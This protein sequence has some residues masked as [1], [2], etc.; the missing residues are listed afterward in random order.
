MRRPSWNKSQVIQQVISL[1][2]LLETTSDSNSDGAPMRLYIPY[3][4]NHSPGHSDSDPPDS[5]VLVMAEESVTN[6]P[7]DS[8]KL[9]APSDISGQIAPAGNNSVS[10]RTVEVTNEPVGQMTIFYRGKV[11]VFDDVPGDKARILMEL[12]ASPL[13][14]PRAT[15][16]EVITTLWPFQCHLQAAEIKLDPTS[17]PVIFP[18]LQTGTSA[19][20]YQKDKIRFFLFIYMIIQRIIE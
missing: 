9:D 7:C 12:A 10:I 14:L 15:P 4:G 17:P 18:R 2:A 16:S 8:P 3:P 1:K 13:L 11:N 20:N 19:G 6:Q 5:R